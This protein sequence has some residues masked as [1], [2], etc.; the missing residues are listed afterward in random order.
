MKSV[1]S[2]MLVVFFLVFNSFSARAALSNDFNII[3][4]FQGGLTSSQQD[5]FADAESFWEMFIVGYQGGIET[6]GLVIQASG[7]D[8]DGVNGVL[9]QAGPNTIFDGS[10]GITYAIAGTMAFDSADLAAME[11]AGTLFDVIVHEMAHV[12]GFGTLW[13]PLYNDLLDAQ[14][15]YIGVNALS[16]YRFE[17]GDDTLDSIPVEQGGGPG[18]QHSHWDET[19]GGGDTEIMTGWL[20]SPAHI[21]LTTVLSFADLGYSVNIAPFFE[22]GPQPVPEPQTIALFLAALLGLTRVK[23]NKA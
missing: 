22:P 23:R 6:E 16:G 15:N 3:V 14:N 20:D 12:I 2:T 18:T 7:E 13:G 21:S 5:I 9:G 8:I 17:Q 19:D 1:I 10:N 11:T 4:D